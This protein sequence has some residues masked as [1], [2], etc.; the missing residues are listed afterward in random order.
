VER[1]PVSHALRWATLCRYNFSCRYCGL[2]AGVVVLQIEHVIPVA[3]GGTSDPWNLVPAC[4]ECNR[5]K[6][7]TMPPADLLRAVWAEYMAHPAPY[8]RQCLVCLEPT[9]SDPACPPLCEDCC[10]RIMA[11]QA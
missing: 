9:L 6:G 3:H 11:V 10:G 4:A 8:V 1:Q 5:G 2:P 7:V